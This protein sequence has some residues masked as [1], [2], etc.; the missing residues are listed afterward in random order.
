MPVFGGILT[1]KETWAGLAFIKSRWPERERAYQ[2][3]MTQQ[4]K[5]S[6]S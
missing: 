2:E 6:R 4:D 5:E 1:D 3:R